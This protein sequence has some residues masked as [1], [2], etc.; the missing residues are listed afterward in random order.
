MNY[1]LPLSDSQ[2]ILTKIAGMLKYT[3]KTKNGELF[4]S[5]MRNALNFETDILLTAIKLF[6]K[7]GMIICDNLND[8]ILKIKEFQSISKDKI[9]KDNLFQDF[10]E[11][12]SKYIYHCSKINNSSFD[13]L[14]RYILE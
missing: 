5:S 14:K 8:E 13:D 9:Q 1:D 3:Y 11:K 7:T 4:F 6:E 10:S 12:Y 2:D